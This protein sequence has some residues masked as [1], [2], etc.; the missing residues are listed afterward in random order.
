MKLQASVLSIL[1]SIFRL[2]LLWLSA[3]T[4]KATSSTA[5]N[6]VSHLER[7]RPTSFQFGYVQK[8]F[9]LKLRGK[10]IANILQVLGRRESKLVRKNSKKLP[11][12]FHYGFVQKNFK[13]KRPE[14]PFK[15]MF[16]QN[17]PNF[18]V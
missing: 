4:Y 14:C 7:F 15:A 3:G 2:G 12:L 17:L 18:K 9:L 16:S 10:R 6:V 13:Q 1:V 11:T 5:A 8:A